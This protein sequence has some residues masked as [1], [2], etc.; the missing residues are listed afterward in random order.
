MKRE[1]SGNIG[2]VA[3]PLGGVIIVCLADIIHC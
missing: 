2:S 3:I 1:L